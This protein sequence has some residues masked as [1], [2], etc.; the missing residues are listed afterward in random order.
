M[1]K[2][3][4]IDGLNEVSHELT[5]RLERIANEGLTV[6]QESAE[7]LVKAYEAQYKTGL[8]LLK[9]ST[10]TLK[11]LAEGELPTKARDLADAALDTARTSADTWL[12]FA[13]SS[14]GR[15]R[16]VVKAAIQGEQAA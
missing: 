13:Q 2:K 1:A 10:E 5:V 7:A 9:K 6:A 16:R 11:G 3:T 4:A 15:V 14:L 8:D 12:E